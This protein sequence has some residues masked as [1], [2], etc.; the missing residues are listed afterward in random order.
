MRARARFDLS[1]AE[2]AQID[3]AF[4]LGPRPRSLPML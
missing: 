1:D 2:L 4:P 3:A